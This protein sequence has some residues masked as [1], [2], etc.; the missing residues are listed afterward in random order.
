MLQV[1]SITMVRFV[2]NYKSLLSLTAIIAFVIA[3]TFYIEK[4]RKKEEKNK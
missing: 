1:L 3:L 4:K 2:F